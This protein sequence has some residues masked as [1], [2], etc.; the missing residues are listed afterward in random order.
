MPELPKAPRSASW[1]SAVSLRYVPQF[2]TDVMDYRLLCSYYGI[3]TYWVAPSDAPEPGTEPDKGAV[4][5]LPLGDVMLFR[6]ALSA[7]D[8]LP[9]LLH[10]SPPAQQLGLRRLLL[11]L[12][13]P[14]KHWC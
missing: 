12:D 5:V 7:T 13:T 6:G 4:Q 9:A 10:K 3:G 14:A 11:R 2:H 1:L 8:R